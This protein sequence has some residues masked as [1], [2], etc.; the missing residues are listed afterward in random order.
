M[1]T[2]TIARA[3]VLG[4]LCAGT[5]AVAGPSTTTTTS[6][7]KTHTIARKVMHKKKGAKKAAAKPVAKPAPAA[8]AK[9]TPAK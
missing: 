4:I 9:T 3:L 7:A 1:M 6:P 8:P 2:K 5:A